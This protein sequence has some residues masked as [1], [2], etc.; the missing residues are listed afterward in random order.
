MDVVLDMADIEP[1]PELI[2]PGHANELNARLAILYPSHNAE[3]DAHGTVLVQIDA[4]LDGLAP[5]QY[6]RRLEQ[7]AGHREIHDVPFPDSRAAGEGYLAR[8]SFFD[9]CS[10]GSQRLLL[11]NSWTDGQIWND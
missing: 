11:G 1:K 8:S 5:F 7:T 9:H 6:E 2:V 4:Q 3:I 10:V